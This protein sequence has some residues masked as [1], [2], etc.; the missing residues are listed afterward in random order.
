[1]TRDFSADLVELR[2]QYASTLPRALA[3]LE[4]LLRAARDRGD[5]AAASARVHRLHGTAGSYGQHRL[6]AVM[7]RIEALLETTPIEARAWQRIE[8]LMAEAR[9]CLDEAP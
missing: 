4:G 1:M 7:A 3:E 6:G 5:V 2:R 9:A 8:E